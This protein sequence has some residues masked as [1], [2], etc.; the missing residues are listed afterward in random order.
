MQIFILDYNIE[1]NA[2]AYVDKHVN[3]ILTEICQILCTVGLEKFPRKVLSVPEYLYKPTHKQHPC[4]LWCKES[5]DNFDYCCLLAKALYNEY[6]FRYNKPDK[7]KR[8][9]K[10]IS[11]WRKHLPNL[12]VKG[13]TPFAQVMPNQY[14]SNDTVK[15][16]R[17]YYLN[18]KNHLFY[19][20]RR[21]RPS[22]L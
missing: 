8:N 17:Q 4:V 3:K 15:A 1:K 2:E 9:L 5:L 6:Q 18:E 10:I 7:H 22:W 12:E 19:W 21:T 16:Y 11:F 20:T 13:L 14:K